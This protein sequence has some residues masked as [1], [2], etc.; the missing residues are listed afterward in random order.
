[1]ENENGDIITLLDENDREVD[2]DLLMSFDYEGKRYVALLP[3]ET[4]EGVEED[5]VVILEVVRE[6]G[7]ESYRPIENPI[8]LDEVFNEF[9][10]L[11][12]EQFDDEDEE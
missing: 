12:D 10:E 6:K 7:G 8:L 1:M 5:E 4:V 3:M 9:Q 11:F 2:F